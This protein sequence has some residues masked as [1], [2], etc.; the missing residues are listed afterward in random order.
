LDIDGVCADFLSAALVIVEQETGVAHRV[1]DLTTWGH[2]E[3]LA[4]AACWARFR[5][6]GFCA[7]LQPY[8]GAVEGVARIRS[9]SDVRALTSPIHGRHW[10]WERA[11]WCRRHLGIPPDLVYFAAHKE[12]V[13]A[14][15]LVDDR[16][17]HV[18]RWA[19]HHPRGIGLLWDQSYNRNEA[20]HSAN[21]RGRI[22]RARSWDDVVQA[23]FDIEGERVQARQPKRS[24]VLGTGR[25]PG[26]SFST[27]L[28]GGTAAV[29]PPA[30]RM[31]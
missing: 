1:E 23:I 15:I 12:L 31:R 17:E 24:S 14:D 2:I 20:T 25:D 28:A 6:E 22:R 18:T 4:S 16:A 13:L 29:E 5:E 19:E 8:A 10:Y 27:G 9:I 30:Q 3:S 21:R 7:S 26:P 11:E